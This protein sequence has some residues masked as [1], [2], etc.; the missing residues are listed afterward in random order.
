MSGSNTGQQSDEGENLQRFVGAGVGIFALGAVAFISAPV[1]IPAIG[2][3]LGAIGVSALSGTA[4]ASGFFVTSAVVGGVVGGVSAPSIYEFASGLFEKKGSGDP[5]TPPKPRPEETP[6]QGPFAQRPKDRQAEPTLGIPISSPATPIQNPNS[7][8]V[9]QPAESS[10]VQ[11]ATIPSVVPNT[12]DAVENRLGKI[13]EHFTN[14]KTPKE[15]LEL[16]DHYRQSA[17]EKVVN[18]GGSFDEK[19]GKIEK[20]FEAT[21]FGFDL[22]ENLEA[23]KDRIKGAIIRETDNFPLDVLA[24]T[25]VKQNS[26]SD[27]ELLYRISYNER[28][29]TKNL[30]YRQTTKDKNKALKCAFD[31]YK[32]SGD[33]QQYPQTSKNQKEYIGEIFRG[34]DF[35]TIFTK[36]DQD[37]SEG[38]ESQSFDWGVAYFPSAKINAA[39]DL[40]LDNKRGGLKPTNSSSLRALAPPLRGSG[41]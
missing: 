16:V 2:I 13:N 15:L 8:S 22:E 34:N 6:L 21:A 14:V 25:P 33:E 29:I 37:V 39:F 12:S 1:A 32:I 5:K 28:Y 41:R 40:D 36:I 30:D 9:L 26:F 18:G 7:P 20:I 10:Q 38:F 17:I 24:S 11:S 27:M 35:R 31:Q 4:I 3:G 23:V 19:K